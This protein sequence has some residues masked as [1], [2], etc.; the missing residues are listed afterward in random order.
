[1]A[2]SSAIRE[3]TVAQMEAGNNEKES[4]P[5]SELN[6]GMTTLKITMTKRE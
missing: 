3:F 5:K 4:K 1:M 2:D 6:S